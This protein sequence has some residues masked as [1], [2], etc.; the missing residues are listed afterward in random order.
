MGGRLVSSLYGTKS[1]ITRQL[2]EVGSRGH[3]SEGTTSLVG[4]THKSLRGLTSGGSVGQ[5]V[6]AQQA[7]SG[8]KVLLHCLMFL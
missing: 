4:G 5:K 2:N 8:G 7:H 3:L 1:H 6:A